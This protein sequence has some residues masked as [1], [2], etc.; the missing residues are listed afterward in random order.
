MKRR[1]NIELRLIAHIV[2]F[3]VLQ[4][5]KQRII[6]LLT[7]TSIWSVT[8][9][10]LYHSSVVH[11]EQGKAYFKTKDGTVPMIAYSR[12]A[13]THAFTWYGT[14]VNNFFPPRYLGSHQHTDSREN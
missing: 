6:D 4:H 7:I 8:R 13:N 10:V 1:M 2:P 3:P 14:A 11:S 12:A 5:Q 9:F